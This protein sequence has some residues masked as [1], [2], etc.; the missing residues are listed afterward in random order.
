MSEIWKDILGYEDTYQV[1]SLGNIR[2]KEHTVA[3]RGGGS[4]TIRERLKKLGYKKDRRVVTT[5]SQNNQLM[6]FSVHQLVAQAFL[7][8]FTKG[9]ELNHI[10]GNPQ[11]NDIANLE[12]SNPSHNQF[13]AV[14]LGLKPKVGIS[15]YRNV[16]YI[17]NPR[18]IKRWAVCLKHNG[19]SSYGWKTFMLEIDAAIYADELLD[20]INDTS[21]LRNF[22]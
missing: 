11:N 9:M 1:S 5:L 15:K 17:S 21:R 20:S 19:K 10:D 16:S 6:T 3:T 12:L 8:S 13:H 7:P 22:P 14:R 2:T 4:R 18:S